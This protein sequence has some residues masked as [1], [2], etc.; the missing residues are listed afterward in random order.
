MEAR[1]IVFVGLSQLF[2]SKKSGFGDDVVTSLS[3]L[4]KNIE[5]D[6]SPRS[7]IEWYYRY[8]GHI[9]RSPLN[10]PPRLVLANK[11]ISF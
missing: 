6:D 1:L 10:F 3:D 9:A 11:L 8:P 4:R 5:E 2:Q 7:Y